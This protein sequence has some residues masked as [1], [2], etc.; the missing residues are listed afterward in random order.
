MLKYKVQFHDFIST[1]LL[2]PEQEELLNSCKT[3]FP[4][5]ASDSG[6][7][8]QLTMPRHAHSFK[9]LGSSAAIELER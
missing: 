2:F 9:L 3:L 5:N 1:Y 4:G 8:I 6:P 7:Q